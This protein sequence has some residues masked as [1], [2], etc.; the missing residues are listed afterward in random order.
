MRPALV[1]ARLTEALPLTVR[2]DVDARLS[3]RR[4][5][6][7]AVAGRVWP[8]FT[9][10]F[11]LGAVDGTWQELSSSSRAYPHPA[12]DRRACARTVPATSR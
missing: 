3:R 5:P 10:M 11:P 7:P 8:T 9:P 4:D 12:A 1:R 6:T 2:R